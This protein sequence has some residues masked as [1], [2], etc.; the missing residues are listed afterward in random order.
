MTTFAPDHPGGGELLTD[1]A[2]SVSA[3]V[4]EDFENA[5]HSTSAK[6]QMKKFYVGDLVQ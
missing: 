5:E 3:E 4:S 1:H 6:N 2:G